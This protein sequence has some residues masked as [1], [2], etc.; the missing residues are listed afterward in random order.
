MD[1]EEVVDKARDDQQRIHLA[2]TDGKVVRIAQLSHRLGRFIRCQ[3]CKQRIGLSVCRG[4]TD[5]VLYVLEGSAEGAVGVSEHDLVELQDIVGLKRDI[6][7]VLMHRVQRVAVACDF[8]LVAGARR[9]LLAHELSQARIR[10][11][12]SLDL[13]GGFCA[14]DLCNLNQLL[15]IG[16]FLT[17]V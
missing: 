13:I 3:G 17:Q 6:L 9:R 8:F 15:H 16:L 1:A 10:R 2:F 7:E 12:D 4:R 14:L 5:I 11:A